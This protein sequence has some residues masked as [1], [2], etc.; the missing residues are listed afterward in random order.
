MTR[1]IGAAGTRGIHGNARSHQ[2]QPRT[3]IER[4]RDQPVDDDGRGGQDEDDRR[5]RITPDSISRLVSRT[6]PQQKNP[7][8]HERE[9]DP[10][11]ENHAR[12]QLTIGAREHQYRRPDGLQRNRPMRSTEPRV[13]VIHPFKEHPIACH[14]EVHARRR[15]NAPHHGAEDR[16]QHQGGN[17]QGPRIPEHD[18]RRIGRH[19]RRRQNLVNR[20]DV[21]IDRIE[22]DIGQGDDRDPDSERPG[23]RPLGC[24]RFL[25]GIGHHVPAAESEEAGDDREQE[26]G[27]G[28]VREP[29]AGAYQH[30][31]TDN[32]MATENRGRSPRR[33]SAPRLRPWSP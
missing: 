1:R 19:A 12:K 6:L 2:R 25:G 21:E 22:C 14:R 26:L 11:G 8:R 15:E 30:P 13:K 24:D 31:S 23:N 3:A 32:A 29:E 27:D 4:K 10:L 16:E 9:E 33:Q 17:S 5:P 20:Q 7:A 28:H 18:R